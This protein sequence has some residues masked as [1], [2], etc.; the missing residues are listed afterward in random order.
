MRNVMRIAT[1]ALFGLVVLP[2]FAA[3]EKK[4]DDKKTDDK[5][6]ELVAAG[7][8][9]GKILHVN[10][11]KHTLKVRVETKE[12]NQGEANAIA[13]LQNE[14]AKIN[15]TEKNPVNRANAI[16]N[17]L[18]DIARRQANLYKIVHKD[19]DV[20]PNDEVKVRRRDLPLK[21]DEKGKPVKY[22]DEEKKAARG[23]D[24]K[25]VGYKAEFSDLR[26]EQMV[27]LVLMKKK[28]TPV[29]PKAEPGKEVDK[30]DVAAILAEYEPRVTTIIIE[31]EPVPK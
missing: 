23:D 28:G 30:S 26:A 4:T 11:S 12:I 14:I 3:D 24:P 20:T 25:A 10:E 6:P 9:T 7:T 19:M 13:N 22:T 27:S 8:I 29:L 21:F 18:N 15:A 17:R 1:G 2:V 5:K 16:Q 31:A